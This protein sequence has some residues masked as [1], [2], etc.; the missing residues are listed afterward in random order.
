L[1]FPAEAVAETKRVPE[2]PEIL[3]VTPELDNNTKSV[4][5]VVN[6]VG[7]VTSPE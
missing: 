1:I 7:I 6:A 3:G 4:V 2:Y 5:S